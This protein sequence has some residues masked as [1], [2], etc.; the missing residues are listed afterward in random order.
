MSYTDF[1]RRAT[2]TEE[3]PDGLTPFPYQD[4][5]AKES[6]PELLDVP[7]GMGKTAAVVLAWLWKRGWRER[8]CEAAPDTETPRRLV[9]CLPMRVLVE[10]TERNACRWLEN[11]AVAGL[12]GD[13]KVSVRLLMGGSDDVKKPTWADYPEEDAILIGTQDM[14]L[15]RALM[16]GY[17][18][19]RYQW[20]VHF[21]WLHNEASWSRN[22][23]AS[24][25]NPL[26]EYR[27]PRPQ[28]RRARAT[29]GHTRSGAA[30]CGSCGASAGH[31]HA[32]NPQHCR[33]GAAP[34]YRSGKPPRGIGGD[35]TTGGAEI[36]KRRT[37]LF[38]QNAFFI[39]DARTARE[40]V[41]FE[42][43][44]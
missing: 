12:P 5:L 15:S 41:L 6:W 8:G 1:F 32:C 29:L 25:G 39:S 28:L 31:H 40:T 3:Q 4:R 17:G 16:R 19:S 14:L 27:A 11:L 9:Y 7:T 20:P 13:N 30:K 2:R 23:T 18:M 22:S 26:S 33:A 24:G 37:H 10:Q 38:H 36:S 35:Q 21:A 43:T 44:S 34:V 42:S